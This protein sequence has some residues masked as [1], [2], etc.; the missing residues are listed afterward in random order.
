[1]SRGGGENI[2][3]GAA[4]PITVVKTLFKNSKGHYANIMSSYTKYIGVGIVIT[5]IGELIYVQQ[6]A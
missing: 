6:F 5:D 4:P 3:H 2:Y 1:G